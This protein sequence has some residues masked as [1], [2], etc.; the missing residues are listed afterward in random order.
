M[1]SFSAACDAR[2]SRH[3]FQHTHNSRM[4]PAN[5]RPTSLSS[6]V[7]T[8]AKAMRRAVAARMPSRIALLRFCGGSPAAA[9]PMTMA[10]SPASTRSIRTTCNKA[11]RASV[12]NR[13]V[14]GMDSSWHERCKGVPVRHRSLMKLPEGPGLA[15]VVL[16]RHR[17]VAEQVEDRV[18]VA[19][20]SGR[21][22]DER[23]RTCY[24]PWGD[25]VAAA[26]RATPPCEQRNSPR[27]RERE[28][29]KYGQHLPA[30]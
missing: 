27:R 28:Q 23:E 12:V 22:A 29:A 3:I 7:V 2:N 17:F 19:Q 16:I 26:G 10:L 21:E 11:V 5:N 13:L 15:V 14:I 24:V 9:R 4:P 1:P 20:H 8:P 25:V 6:W 18:G 30:R